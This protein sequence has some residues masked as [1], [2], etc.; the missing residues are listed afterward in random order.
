MFCY[1]TLSDFNASFKSLL[2]HDL[3]FA[4]YIGFPSNN[5]EDLGSI[6]SSF[7]GCLITIYNSYCMIH[8]LNDNLRDFPTVRNKEVSFLSLPYFPPHFLVLLVPLL[9]KNILLH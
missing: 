8:F 7:S 4:F 5:L 3:R 2:L 1:I 9:F 6:F